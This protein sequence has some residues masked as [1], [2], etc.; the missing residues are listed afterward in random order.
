MNLSLF[1]LPPQT[2]P[3]VGRKRELAAITEQLANPDCRLLTLVGPGGIGKTRLAIEAATHQRGT[4]ADGIAF[5]PLQALNSHD[6]IV[7]AIAEA[8]EFEVGHCCD[9][10]KELIDYLRDKTLL[11]VLD[12][13]EH[14]LAGVDLVSRMLAAAPG[15]VIM[16]TSRE[17]LN[18]QEE[19]LW[20]V[21]G[22]RFPDLADVQNGGALHLDDY[23]AVQLFAQSAQRISA[24]F[25][26]EENLA[27]VVRICT[28]VEGMPLGLELAA[29]W[30][31]V[32]SCEEIA[33][34]IRRNLDFLATRTRNVEPRHRSV[35]VALDHSWKLLTEAEQQ[36]FS[37]LSVFRGHFTRDAAVTVTGAPLAELSALVD[38][39]LLRHDTAGH[40]DQHEMV[41]QY[42]EKQL[43]AVM[44][45]SIETR[46]RHARFYLGQLERYWSDL[47]GSRPTE[48]LQ[49]IEED[50]K[51]VR[52]AWSWAAI[53][54]GHRDLD[55]SA[56]SF[57]FFYDTRG[58]YHEGQKMFGLAVEAVR[59][60]N[61]G[62]TCLLLGKLL[63][64]QG[65]LCNS[66]SW[67]DK[68]QALLE[69]AL[70]IFREHDSQDCIAFALLRLGEVASFQVRHEEAFSLFEQSFEVYEAV[71]DRWGQAYVLN[72]LG[73]TA[74]DPSLRRDHIEHSA[75]IFEEIGSRWGTGIVLP[76]RAY[77]ALNTQDYERAIQLGIEAV[78]LCQEVG[79]PWGKAMG[80][81][82]MGYGYYYMGAIQDARH[83]FEKALRI[84]I[85]I[86][87]EHFV[88]MTSYGLGLTLLAENHNDMAC[89]LLAITYQ[90]YLKVGRFSK[91]YDL[92]EVLASIRSKAKQRAQDIDP[93][94]TAKRIL[95]AIEQMPDAPAPDAASGDGPDVLT[96]REGEILGLVAGGMTNR[97]IAE[98]L[99]L[100]TGTV[101]WYLSQ[102]YS[103]LGVNSRTQAVA[104]A[105]ELSLLEGMN[106]KTNP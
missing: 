24:D 54:D 39:S 15:L 70:A 46:D 32:L 60:A 29:A 85:G 61:P 7:P 21:T 92:R 72:W 38:K 101:K 50:I 77:L 53:H 1:N 103:K 10:D 17:A 35:R 43:N 25:S 40:F 11:L 96:E 97:D 66:L 69:E 75:A 30:M 8:L 23:S 27:C 95:A 26:L 59:D 106:A 51:N 74:D 9:P 65:V 37:R 90:Y 93:E 68:A 87:L 52:V 81:E 28:L 56:H 5:V 3:F 102:V 94:A 79:I 78:E 73:L 45:D 34:E 64:W 100:S 13:F 71:G 2:T 88:A 58:W 104:R 55:R 57:G 33:R 63:A 31:R 22:M 42:A 6:F 84:S 19:W 36:V 91:F 98:R 16:V 99:Y 82:S 62:T 48:A 80:Y 14:V 67:F 4:Y 86:H 76:S 105:R 12:N 47:H 18:I 83:C 89:D 41:R 20:P 44:D 49:N